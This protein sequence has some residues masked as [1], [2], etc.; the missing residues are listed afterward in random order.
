MDNV[1][2]HILLAEDDENDR[3][4]FTEAFSD[5][6]LETIIQA[7]N[8]GVQLMEWLAKERSTLPHM[9]FL[10]LNMPRKNGL[11]CLKE[12]RGNEEFNNVF[13][14]IYSTSSNQRDMEETFLNGANVYITKPSGFNDLKQ[15]LAKA[16][17]RAHFYR[18]ASMKKENFLLRL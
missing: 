13:I 12:I 6:K 9:L 7:V 14:A 5:L 2:F 17:M 4:L 10:D 11:D 1:P 18:D 8:D 15:V 16:V 3:L